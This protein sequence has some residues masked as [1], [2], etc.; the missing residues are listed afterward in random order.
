MAS[1]TWRHVIN[2]HFELSYLELNS[3]HDLASDSSCPRMH[4]MTRREIS[5]GPYEADRFITFGTKHVKLWIPAGENRAAMG[6]TNKGAV[7]AARS[8]T[9]KMCS[10]G[11]DESIPLPSSSTRV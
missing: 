7:T 3:I 6:V 4:P 5:A 1:M 9:G 11:G 8:Y 10:F 2:T